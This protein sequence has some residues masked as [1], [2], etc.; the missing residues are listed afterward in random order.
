MISGNMACIVCGTPGKNSPV[1]SDDKPADPSNDGMRAKWECPRC[2][3]FETSGPV[4]GPLKNE[5][6]DH[7]RAKI[8]GWIRDQNNRHSSAKINDYV[9]GCII[10][11]PLPSIPERM[12]QL[13]VEAAR[14]QEC[15]GSEIE[16]RLPSFFASTYSKDAEELYFFHNMLSEK[17]FTRHIGKIFKI[18][19]EGYVRLDELTRK[20]SNS[21]RGFVAMWFSKEL[22]PAYGGFEKGI[23]GAGY[24]PI[25]IDRTE[26]IN[27][28]DDEIIVQIKQSR[29]VVADFTGH[30]GSVYFEAG[31]ALGLDLP[32]IWTC[33]KDHMEDLHFDIRQFNYIDWDTKEDL[34]KRL[35][36]R[37][38]A[39]IG[40]GP[41]KVLG[42]RP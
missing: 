6:D 20:A 28:I 3:Q 15:L 17:G 25:R 16:F 4:Q 33:R 10:A 11:K 32:V 23:R 29:F 14:V 8:S 34:A 1:L 24:E 18:T 22:D 36:N 35:Q 31:F 42:H 19:L 27:R 41:G 37:I 40:P 30:R 39:V 21:S 2:G 9:L 26:Y 12:D 38:E 7:I 5:S 13:L